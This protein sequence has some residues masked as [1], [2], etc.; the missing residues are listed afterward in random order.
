MALL[1]GALSGA[2]VALTMGV[3]AWLTRM[4]WGDPVEEGLERQIPL[5]WSMGV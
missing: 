1:T 4:L 5:L 2:A 3:I